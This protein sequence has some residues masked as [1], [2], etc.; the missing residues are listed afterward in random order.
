MKLHNIA[1]SIIIAFILLSCSQ[2]PEAVL[3]K[4]LKVY[5]KEGVSVKAYNFEQFEYF[6]TRKNDTTYVVNFWA[7]WCIPCVEE[8]PYFE[9]LSQAHKDD[10]VKV[11]LVSLDMPK[12][13]ETKLLPFIKEKNMKNEVVLLRDPDAN[14]WISRVDKTWS[15]AIPATII[16]NSDKRKFYEKSFTY[17][18]LTK[19]IN[20]FKP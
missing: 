11:L 4:P 3:P 14:T 17:E 18:E 13:V 20:K 7:T 19:E 16:Y 10:K 12:M 1:T 9:R 15:G 6:L 2:R 8:L 5:H